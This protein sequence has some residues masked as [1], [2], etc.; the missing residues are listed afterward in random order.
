MDEP[1]GNVEE[2]PPNSNE[3]NHLISAGAYARRF[4]NA[5]NRKGTEA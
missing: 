2:P 1:T 3:F 5:L 4:I